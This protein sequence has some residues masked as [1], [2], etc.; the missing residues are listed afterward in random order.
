MNQINLLISI[1]ALIIAIL[2][3]LNSLEQFQN[4]LCQ[5]KVRFLE[6]EDEEGKEI[7]VLSH[8]KPILF[9][10]EFKQRTGASIIDYIAIRKPSQIIP[11]TPR[12]LDS[13]HD[14]IDRDERGYIL[15]LNP[16]SHRIIFFEL[17]LDE[18]YHNIDHVDF[19]ICVIT[20]DKIYSNKMKMVIDGQILQNE[21]NDD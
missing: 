13:N 16:K 2:A 6:P 19:Y 4:W 14:E 21:D 3:L 9:P 8:N 20:T 17:S 7:W 1:A 15:K 10:I 5:P 11:A 12:F 18:D